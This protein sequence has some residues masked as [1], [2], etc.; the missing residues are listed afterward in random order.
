MKNGFKSLILA[1]AFSSSLAAP[2]LAHGNGDRDWNHQPPAKSSTAGS[3]AVGAG[4][5]VLAGALIYSSI[6]S[7]SEPQQ[8]PVSAVEADAHRPAGNVAYYQDADARKPIP[9][10]AYN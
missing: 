1:I 8:I 9:M 7:N 4:L 10:N 2:A 5:A 3:I 6:H